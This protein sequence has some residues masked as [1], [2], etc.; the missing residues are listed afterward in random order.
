MDD[1][2]QP[3]PQEAREQLAAAQARQLGSAR[4]RR[5][6][7]VGTA[8][9]G[10][11]VGVFMA[12]QNMVSLGTSG[13]LL[14]VAFAVVCLGEAWWVE[15]AARTVPRRSRLWSRLGIGGS[16]VLALVV[17]MPWL[18]LSAQS[19]PNTWPMVTVGAAVAAA[20]SVIAAAA[21]A[22]GRRG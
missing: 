4:D 22:A 5:I 10:L 16:V 18:N 7:A 3:T 9:L 14:F 13:A 12:T 8:V 15:R 17:V 20:P 11:T 2:H 19:G 21:I 1:R 6:H